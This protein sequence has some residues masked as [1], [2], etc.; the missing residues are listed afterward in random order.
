M[1]ATPERLAKGDHSEMVKPAEIDDTEQAIG[2][3]RR[4]RTSH[5]DRL[6]K[7]ARLS[8]RQ[9]YA[10]DWYRNLHQRGRFRLHVV[11]SYGAKKKGGEM[12]SGQP[13]P[14]ARQNGKAASRDRES[15]D[16]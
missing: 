9:L 8:W 7:N 11:A 6:H 10:A 3:V 14:E 13:A 1:D 15:Q 2:R 12:E 5:L 4:F 16:G